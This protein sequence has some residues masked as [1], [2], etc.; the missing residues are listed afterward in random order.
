MVYFPFNIEQGANALKQ[1]KIIAYPTEAVF[2]LGCCPRNEKALSDL[3]HI[4]QRVPNKGMI[5]IASEIAQILP[6]IDLSS[7]P[8][9]KWQQ[10]QQKWPGPYTFV[11]PASVEVHSLI[12]ANIRQ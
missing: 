5:L 7:V 9:E 10:I 6:F 2:G 3:L 12:K 11:F 4:K 1:G 8:E